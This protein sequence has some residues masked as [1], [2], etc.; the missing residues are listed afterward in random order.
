MR[1]FH[2]GSEQIFHDIEIYLTEKEARELIGGVN[3]L[4]DHIEK[5]DDHQMITFPDEDGND[6]TKELSVIVYNKENYQHFEER[7]VRLLDKDEDER[8]NR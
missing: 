2:R 8:V 5:A 6:F 7:T 4:L 1:I 3:W